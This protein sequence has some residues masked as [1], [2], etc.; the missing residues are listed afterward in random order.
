MGRTVSVLSSL[1]VFF[2]L[3]AAFMVAAPR[4]AKALTCS[5]A[6]TDV[7]FG[8]VNLLSAS[9]TDVA[10][11]ITIT[12][13]AI[14]LGEVVKM[15]P[16][17]DD[18]TGG[19]NGLTRYMK[20]Q[21]HAL[22]LAYGLYQDAAR[23]VPWGSVTRPELGSVPAVLLSSIT[24]TAVATRTLYARL[25]GGQIAAPADYY[26]SGFEGADA[27]FT[28]TAYLLAA[29]TNCTGFVGLHVVHPEF[30][31]VATPGAGCTLAT[32]NMTFPNT[33]VLDHVVTAQGALGVT[34]TNLAP[35]SISLDNGQNG[36]SPTARR[37]K[38][39][40]GD[41]VTYALYRDSART[42]PWGTASSS[43]GVSG[44]GLGTQQAFPVYGQ[45]PIQGTP[46]PGTYTDTVVVTVTY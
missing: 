45:V 44:T 28:W 12:C 40:T 11:T 16:S 3:L 36:T 39:G 37:M 13:T 19:S 24:G 4:E 29:T 23:T 35:Y 10:A 20:G 8:T 21:G 41:M 42:L 15:C 14:P 25:P 26:Q 33:G 27:A 18:G 31:V 6:V 32:A 9:P 43:Q 30:D 7:D 17:I 5:A 46:R 34:C 22:P 2:L 38:S 1:S